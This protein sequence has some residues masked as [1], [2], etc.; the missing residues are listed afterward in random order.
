MAAKKEC[1]YCKEYG[2]DHIR[3]NTGSFCNMDHAIR[4]SLE[5]TAKDK[6]GA[7]KKAETAKKKE[8]TQKKREFYDN[9]IKTRKK[10]AKLACHLYI[11]TRDKDLKC[12]CCDRP[13][14]KSFDA[15]HWLE[16]GNN[17]KIRYHE[18]NI[19]AQAVYCNQYKGGDSGNYEENLRKKIGDERVDWLKSQKGGTMKRTAQDYKEIELYFKQKLKELEE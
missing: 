17:P 1:K 15:G 13:L 10:A 5:K 8:H 9:D 7:Q 18:D 6:L 11:R 4:W 14:G 2:Y 16:S 19:N 3:V 12:I